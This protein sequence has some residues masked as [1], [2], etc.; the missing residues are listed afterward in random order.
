MSPVS[1]PDA[2]YRSDLLAHPI[3]STVL[4]LL[5]LSS[6]SSTQICI[7]LLPRLSNPQILPYYLYAGVS[8]P[9]PLQRPMSSSVNPGIS[10]PLRA[11][12]LLNKQDRRNPRHD[13]VEGNRVHGLT[14][15][16]YLS[17]IN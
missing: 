14:P 9:Y 8:H 1:S 17:F 10:H 2:L 13:M 6:T 5:A 4:V 12:L 15:T 7:T 11:I 3:L 16:I